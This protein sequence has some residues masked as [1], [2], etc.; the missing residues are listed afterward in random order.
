[1]T[2]KEKAEQEKAAT[3]AAEKSK[4]DADAKAKADA[5]A[6]DPLKSELDRVKSK[7]PE[8]SEKEKAEFTLKRNAERVKE[9]GGDPNIVL[10]VHTSDDDN[11]D[12]KPMTVGAFKRF[13]QEFASRSALQ[14]ADEIT[15]ETE[16]ELVKYHIQNTI[17]SS[18]NSQEDL[19][20]ART[21]T[22]A[23]K[24]SQILE[25]QQRKIQSKTYSSSSGVNATYDP[26]EGAELTNSEKRFLGKPWKMT[27]EQIIAARKPQKQREVLD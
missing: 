6:Q 5:A 9:L 22:N 17:R 8:F 4:A 26:I 25:E 1:M 10:G 14:L 23:A 15:N 11:D 21:L 13:Q 24:N 7:K 18:G 19:R 20:I 2:E 3:L 16:R 12:D 27:K